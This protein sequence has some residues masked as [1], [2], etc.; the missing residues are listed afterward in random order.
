MMQEGDPTV[1]DE[2]K[3]MAAI[4]FFGPREIL[5]LVIVAVNTGDL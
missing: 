1:R 4:Y 5:G 2:L 3:L